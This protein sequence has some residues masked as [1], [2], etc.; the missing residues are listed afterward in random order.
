[1]DVCI[2][3]GA[4]DTE[5]PYLQWLYRFKKIIKFSHFD[6]ASRK[7]KKKPKNTAVL[8]GSCTPQASLHLTNLCINLFHSLKIPWV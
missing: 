4:N 8:D 6:K 5:D 7:K 3:R 2:Y 1:M